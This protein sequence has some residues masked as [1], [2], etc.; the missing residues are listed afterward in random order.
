MSLSKALYTSYLVLSVRKH[1]RGFYFRETLHYCK[2]GNFREGFIYA[3]LRSFEK[4]KTS[5]NDEITLSFVDI[6]K[7]CPSREF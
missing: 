5:R 3:T 7:S 2:F 6:A 1:S 4:L